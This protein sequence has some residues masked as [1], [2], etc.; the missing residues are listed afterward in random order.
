[1]LYISKCKG[2]KW[3]IK[4]TDIKVETFH[5]VSEIKGYLKEGKRISGAIL[6]SDG[7]IVISKSVAYMSKLDLVKSKMLYGVY[8]VAEGFELQIINDE[9]IATEI[10]ESYFRTRIKE[11][12]NTDSFVLTLP[13]IVTNLDSYFFGNFFYIDFVGT[14]VIDLP[15]SL[16]GIDSLAMSSRYRGCTNVVVKFN[17]VID[18]IG[19]GAEDTVYLNEDSLSLNNYTVPVKLIKDRSLALVLRDDRI[20][21]FPY[22]EEIG[23][24][25]VRIILSNSILSLI[26]H[27][28]RDYFVFQF[29]FGSNLRVLKNFAQCELAD[30]V[31]IYNVVYLDDCSSIEFVDFSDLWDSSMDI[32]FYLFVVKKD[33]VHLFKELFQGKEMDDRTA[34]GILG[35]S[36]EDEKSYLQANMD[37]FFSD[38]MKYFGL[39]YCDLMETCE[40][41]NLINQ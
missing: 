17:S 21:K 26:Q 5:T 30:T 20:I 35:Y 22:I 8:R 23:V 32:R 33:Q 25:S 4:D 37:R 16:R 27:K 3:G 7:E 14:V 38:T 11:L 28:V 19:A 18:K 40:E 41:I 15:S 34:I 2:A 10:E 13:D 39:D 29:E 31:S 6:L 9:I 12:N 1:M 24:G 36:D